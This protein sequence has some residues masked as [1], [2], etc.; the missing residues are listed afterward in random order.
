MNNLLSGFIG[1]LILFGIQ[2][3]VDFI[4]QIKHKRRTKFLLGIYLKKLK[5]TLLGCANSTIE[6]SRHIDGH[7]RAITEP[8]L[9][10]LL[11]GKISAQVP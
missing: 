2:N 5:I 3:G 1:A 10:P 11:G 9:L 6:M 8:F 7:R 4:K